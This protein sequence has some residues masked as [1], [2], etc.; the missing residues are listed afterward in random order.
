MEVHKNLGIW[1]DHSN[2]NL[3][4]LNKV[5]NNYSISSKFTFSTKE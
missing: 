4:D 2:A 1:M 5:K 3:M